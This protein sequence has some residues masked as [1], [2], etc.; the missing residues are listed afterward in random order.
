MEFVVV[1]LNDDDAENEDTFMHPQLEQFVREA[2][3]SQR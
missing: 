2:I 1:P 3:A